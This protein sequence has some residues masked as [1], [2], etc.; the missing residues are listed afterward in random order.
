MISS[1]GFLI[2]NKPE[3][4]TSFDVVAKV[5][6]A[7]RLEE[8]AVRWKKV[9]VKVGHLGTLDPVATGVLVLAVGEATKLI[10]YWM[11]AD[12][13]YEAEFEFGKVSDT[14]DREGKIEVKDEAAARRVT[15][16]EVEQ[17]LHGF[18]GEIEQVPP[19]FSA[20][21][22]KGERAYALARRGEK[23]ELKA[24]KVMVHSI[25]I[26]GFHEATEGGH[27]GEG[28]GHPPGRGRGP[29]LMLKVH[30]GSGT[31]LRSLAHD[32]GEKLGCGALMSDL[33]RTAVGPFTLSQ[34][35]A[36]PKDAAEASAAPFYRD[37]LIPLEKI[38]ESWPHFALDPRQVR[39]LKN[40]QMIPLP[41]GFPRGVGAGMPPSFPVVGTYEGKV[42][43]LLGIEALHLVK[44]LKGFS[45]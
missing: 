2:V 26:Q 17:A 4:L 7:L 19:A 21:K 45:R 28:R 14:Y 18:V 31:Y 43:A 44:V 42:V 37:H 29:M 15:R 22:V 16:E 36:L 30:C 27:T 33:V 13:V 40:G 38:M 24:R 8:L 12:K 41:P 34:V 1:N 39:Q 11:G 3:G 23:V 35:I 6:R 5:R 10:E 9:E 25:N 32:L 20:V